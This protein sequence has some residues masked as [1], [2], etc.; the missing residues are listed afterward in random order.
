MPKTFHYKLNVRSYNLDSF[1]HVNNAVY[2][3]YLEEARCNY[4]E[5]MGLSFMDFHRLKA[6]A[7]VVSVHI[8]Y[9]S[10]AKFNDLLDI[11]GQFSKVRR[12]SFSTR[13]VIYNETTQRICAEAD[14]SFAFVDEKGKVI[15][16]PSLFRDKILQA[17]EQD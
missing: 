1:G 3:N 12:S 7:F 16:M 14:M 15:P 6:F 8:D 10:P 2:L 4:L 13:F 9:K 17:C 5:Q 11:Q